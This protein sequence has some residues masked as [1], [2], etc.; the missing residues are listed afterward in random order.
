MLGNILCIYL[1]GLIVGTKANKEFEEGE[2]YRI[3]NFYIVG[4]NYEIEEQ[5]R[6]M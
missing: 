1:S 3:R 2:R 4:R 5:S 6:N